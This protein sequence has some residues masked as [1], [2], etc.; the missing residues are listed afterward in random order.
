M[1]GFYNYNKTALYR[2]CS[3]FNLQW[4][5]GSSSFSRGWF[6]LGPPRTYGRGTLDEDEP[7]AATV[8]M[9]TYMYMHV[10][11]VH[12][13]KYVCKEVHYCTPTH[14]EGQSGDKQ[15]RPD[16]DQVVKLR[17]WGKL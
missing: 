9:F 8:C 15:S 5:F 14:D 4:L 6:S 2:S 7:A 1:D 11:I 16:F 13:Y 3:S 12:V 10:S 17:T